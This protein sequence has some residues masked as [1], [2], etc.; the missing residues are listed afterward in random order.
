M[1]IH[2]SEKNVCVKL[3]LDLRWN[4]TWHYGWLSFWKHSNISLNQITKSVNSVRLHHDCW[5]GLHIQSS[6]RVLFFPPKLLSVKMCLS[7]N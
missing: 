6:A 4:H 1:K 7:T 3:K 5:F 2:P